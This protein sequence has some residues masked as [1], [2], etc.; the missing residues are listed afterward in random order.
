MPTTVTY[1]GQSMSWQDFLKNSYTNAFLVVRDETISSEVPAVFAFTLHPVALVNGLTQSTVLSLL[2]FS[3]YPAQT[4]RLSA[5][6][7]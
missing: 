7:A 4:I 3:A 5:P 1:K 2:P 6:E